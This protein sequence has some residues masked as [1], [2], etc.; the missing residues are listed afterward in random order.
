MTRDTEQLR[1]FAE[2]DTAAW[3]TPASSS[4]ESER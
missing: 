4:T 1:A 2:R 3:C